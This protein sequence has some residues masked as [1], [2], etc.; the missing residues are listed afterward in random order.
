MQ[1][2]KFTVLKRKTEWDIPE[3]NILSRLIRGLVYRYDKDP[4]VI[5]APGEYSRESVE[6]TLGY[7]NFE[8]VIVSDIADLPQSLGPEISRAMANMHTEKK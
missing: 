3:V 7:G 6:D 8:H 1:D 2:L 4:G 5:V